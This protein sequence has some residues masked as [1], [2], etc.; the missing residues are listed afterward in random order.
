MSKKKRKKLKQHHLFEIECHTEQIPN[1]ID[2]DKDGIAWKCFKE[3]RTRV[4]INHVMLDEETSRKI[5]K[6]MTH[7]LNKFWD[8]YEQ[9]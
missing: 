3:G 8:K 6:G 5:I 2:V 4:I 9:K 1:G 7:N